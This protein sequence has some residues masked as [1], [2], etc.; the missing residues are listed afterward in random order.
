M[1]HTGFESS[2][3]PSEPGL[4]SHDYELCPVF[5]SYLSVELLKLVIYLSIQNLYIRIA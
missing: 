1:Y 2:A 5:V 4:P 3:K